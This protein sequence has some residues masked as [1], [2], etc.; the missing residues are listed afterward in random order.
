MNEKLVILYFCQQDRL[1]TSSTRKKDKLHED[2]LI[3]HLKMKKEV[4]AGKYQ[5]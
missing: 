4:N 1:Y 5:L 3:F 2:K